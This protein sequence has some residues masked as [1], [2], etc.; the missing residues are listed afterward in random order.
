M[1]LAARLIRSKI[2][3]NDMRTRYIPTVRDAI[4]VGMGAGV[5][6]VRTV[7]RDVACEAAWAAACIVALVIACAVNTERIHMIMRRDHM[8]VRSTSAS[9]RGKSSVENLGTMIEGTRSLGSLGF[10]GNGADSRRKHFVYRSYQPYIDS[11]T[12]HGRP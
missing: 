9:V 11:N 8:V 3:D 4:A 12:D 10:R 5:V 1:A 6:I 7:I 2:G